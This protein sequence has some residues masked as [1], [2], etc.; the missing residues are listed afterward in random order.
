[1]SRTTVRSEQVRDDSLLIDDLRDFAPT[2]G[3]GLVL[4]V[5]AGRIRNDNVITEQSSQNLTLTASSTNYVEINS[6]GV[7]SF[8]TTGFTAG[9]IPVAIV[10]TN[11]TTIT[12][13]AD[14]RTWVAVDN[15]SGSGST[16]SFSRNF[17]TMGA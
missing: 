15:N 4:T 12:S 3:A 16:P 1:M 5:L 11:V 17:L 7:A 10:G 6:T 13:I 8:N 9:R 2:Q 14:K